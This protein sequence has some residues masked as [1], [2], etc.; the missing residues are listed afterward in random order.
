MSQGLKRWSKRIYYSTWIAMFKTEKQQQIMSSH[1]TCCHTSLRFTWIWL[2]GRIRQEKLM[3]EEP[4]WQCG[5]TFQFLP[6]LKCLA[7]HLSNLAAQN[8]K[9]SCK[10]FQVL[11]VI[12]AFTTVTP[13]ILA[14]RR[15]KNAQTLAILAF[16]SFSTCLRVT[17]R[18]TPKGIGC[19]FNPRPSLVWGPDTST[20]GSSGFLDASR[21]K[22]HLRLGLEKHFFFPK[23]NPTPYDVLH[24]EFQG[25][26]SLEHSSRSVMKLHQTQRNLSVFLSLFRTCEHCLQNIFYFFLSP[27]QC[28]SPTSASASTGPWPQE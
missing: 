24:R 7:P 11:F 15:P 4:G 28:R 21:N 8:C 16:L 20:P 18:D 26:Y 19:E 9:C 2:T 25:C 27:W 14:S 6:L 12:V 5:Q 1:H 22:I 13:R 3:G 10:E 23:S 17:L